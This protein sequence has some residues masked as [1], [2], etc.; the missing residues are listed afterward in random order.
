MP[1]ELSAFTT[2]IAN[3]ATESAAINL[4]D[5]TLCG[6]FLPAAFT[7]ASVTFLAASTLAGTYVEV[8]DGDGAAISRTVA[9]SKF[10]PIDPVDF[11][12]VKF[13][14]IKSASAEAAL[15][16]LTVMGRDL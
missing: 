15:R 4:R 6:I 14:K 13:L 2:T 12:G 1:S 10:I 9:A 11:L 5:F 7:G 3:G 16:T 8:Q